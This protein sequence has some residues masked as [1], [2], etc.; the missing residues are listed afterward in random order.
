MN[1]HDLPGDPGR[2]EK[3]KRI[4]RGRGTGQGTFAGKGCKGQKSRSGAS[5][6]ASFQGGQMPL[7]RRFPKR[8]FNNKFRIEYSV[9]NVGRLAE[10]FND[11]D[12]VDVA[13]LKERR[14]VKGVKPMV[15]VLGVGEISKPL[16]V[17]A[18]K[19]SRSAI[20]KITAAG[21]K[22]EVID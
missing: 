9:V 1:I 7:T 2:R 16:V 5:I 11:N 12:T 19:F 3:K 13:I 22:C 20:E 4:G 21:G 15:K 6:P 17:R 8:G 18:H 14:V 10:L